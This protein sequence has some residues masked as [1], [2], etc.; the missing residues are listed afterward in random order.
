MENHLPETK[1]VATMMLM[2]AKSIVCYKT[3]N[4]MRSL[5]TVGTAP[6]PAQCG[7]SGR[8]YSILFDI[9]YNKI[10]TLTEIAKKQGQTLSSLSS[11]VSKMEDN[12][13]IKRE[14]PETSGVLDGRKIYFNLTNSGCELLNRFTEL[15]TNEL[16]RFYSS[17]SDTE[18]ESFTSGF[19]MLKTFVS[20]GDDIRL[21]VPCSPLAAE[22]LKS[23]IIATNWLGNN[24]LNEFNK[25]NKGIE[26]LTMPQFVIL[27]HIYFFGISTIP[28]LALI[29]GV[30]QSTMSTAIKHLTAAGHILKERLPK[31]QDKR[32][33][34]LTITEKGISAI[35]STL[36]NLY[37][38]FKKHY[39]TM[40]QTQQKTL[41]TGILEL[42]KVFISLE[43][44]RESNRE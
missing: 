18:K 15:V 25:N 10:R 27:C 22:I 24:Y 17:L 7:A 16:D 37:N 4:I 39:E 34:A 26:K 2:L 23:I 28:S 41:Y 43:A 5:T 42:H 44:K 40:S 20:G 29:A 21:N 38:I 1:E 30:S 35:K 3:S 33:V 9:G 8:Q 6:G 14:Y 12:G 36:D 13:Y 19:N 32:K 31:E 11:I